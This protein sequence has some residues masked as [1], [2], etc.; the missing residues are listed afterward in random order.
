[1]S[2]THLLNLEY[3]QFILLIKKKMSDEMSKNGFYV[4]LIII[5]KELIEKTKGMRKHQ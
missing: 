5:G 1:M 3:L 2:R 4:H